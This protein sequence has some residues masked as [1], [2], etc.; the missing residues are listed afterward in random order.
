[1]L[2]GQRKGWPGLALGTAAAPGVAGPVWLL[3]CPVASRY[4]GLGP[5][6]VVAEG[7]LRSARW[8]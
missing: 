7:T 1:M 8:M 6:G 3:R 5:A 2:P 4:L